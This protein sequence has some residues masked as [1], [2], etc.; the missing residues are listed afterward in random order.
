MAFAGLLNAE[1][2]ELEAAGV[3]VIQFDEPAF[4]VFMND[5]VDW[6][7]AALN[8]AIE[9]LRCRTAVH[10]CYGYGIKASGTFD[11]TT[12]EV[13]TAFQRHFR[14]ER[15]DGVADQSTLKTLQILLESLPAQARAG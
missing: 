11:K 7:V 12:A 5:V 2:R 15:V 4:N 1:A 6:G 13:V 10:I 3:D 8:R 9:G 14:P